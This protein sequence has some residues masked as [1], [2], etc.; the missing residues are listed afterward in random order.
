M[1]NNDHE[2]IKKWIGAINRIDNRKRCSSD[3]SLSLL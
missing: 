3:I 2:L 1:K